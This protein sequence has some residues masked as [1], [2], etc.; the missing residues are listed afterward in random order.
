MYVYIYVFNHVHPLF[1]DGEL[2][3]KSQSIQRHYEMLEYLVDG[4]TG[5]IS[6]RWTNSK[7][8]DVKENT[9]ISKNSS[10]KNVS[11]G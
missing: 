4:S 2:I 3:D 1:D 6:C 10:P 7:W 8:V 9:V 5:N 11:K